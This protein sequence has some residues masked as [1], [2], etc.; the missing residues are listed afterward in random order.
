M[1]KKKEEGGLSG[2]WAEIYEVKSAKQNSN[3]RMA[4]RQASNF[5][6]PNGIVRP[7]PKDKDEQ[8]EEIGVNNIGSTNCD[9]T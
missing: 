4:S 3:Y 1:K 9:P 6:F 2:L 8:K 5:V 7:R